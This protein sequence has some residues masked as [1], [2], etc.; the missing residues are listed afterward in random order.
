MAR[1]LFALALALSA[2][3]GCSNRKYPGQCRTTQGALGLGIDDVQAPPVD[4]AT[5]GRQAARVD[6]ALAEW[7]V[8]KAA[9]TLAD[10]RAAA[11]ALQALLSERKALLASASG[12][13]QSGEMRHAIEI[14]GASYLAKFQAMTA[15]CAAPR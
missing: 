4:E 8:A 11:N 3:A 5:R 12:R 13:L 7:D 14:N 10:L 1:R 2:L 15:L 9:V 6:R